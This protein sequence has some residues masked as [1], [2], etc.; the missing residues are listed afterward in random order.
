MR[1]P[2]T[3]PFLALIALVISSCSP[4]AVP[5]VQSP[6][7][8]GDI[9]IIPQPVRIVRV[10]G[11]FELN[12]E[13]KIVV[14]EEAGRGAAAIL[15]E[16]LTRHHG[17]GLAFSDG[18]DIQNSITFSQPSP[19]DDLGDEG[20]FLG[21]RPGR[22]QIVGSERGMF[23]AVNS[24]AQLLP[25]GFQT[26]ATIPAADIFDAPRFVYRGMHMDVARHF[27]KVEFVKKFI[28]LLSRYKFNYFHW[29]LTDDQG[30]RI[31][32]K[33][34]PRLTEIGSRRRE[35][36]VGR[37]E[38]PYV[39]DRI[40]VE[41]YYTQE[42][43]REV[44]AFAKSRYITVIPEI[45]MPG[46]SA[47]ALAAYPELGCRAGY[48]YQVQTTWAASTNILCPTQRT[49][50]FIADVVAEVVGLFPDSPYIHIGGDEVKQ[51]QWR[52]SGYVTALKRS[53]GLNS[54]PDM[55]AWF[56]RQAGR[57]VNAH[58]K[59]IIG[60]DEIVEGGAPP[61][62]VV[63]SWR[64]E[65][66][67]IAAARAGHKVIMTPSTFTYFDHPQGDPEFEP[68]GLGPQINLRK[69]YEY[70]PIPKTMSEAD[71]KFVM[72]AQGCVWTEFIKTPRDVEY[73]AFPRAL[74]LAEV[75]WSKKNRRN[76]DG[77]VD[78][79][80][81]EF[82]RLDRDNVNY[83]IPAPAGLGDRRFSISEKAVVDLKSAVPNG[84]IYYTVDGTDPDADSCLYQGP[85][86]LDLAPLQ[87]VK[88]RVRIIASETRKSPVFVAQYVRDT[89]A[90]VLK[91]P[92][93][94]E[95]SN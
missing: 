43:I 17:F 37:S 53:K 7:Q 36:M 76:Y 95:K 29:H 9:L 92:G 84:N 44:V 85:F 23:Y 74:A 75:L 81:N 15:N 33:K 83:R 12:R 79:L 27:M 87:M 22:I 68:P 69:V 66:G 45:E 28:D 19:A 55:N 61:D 13:T 70:E 52:E 58:E 2:L 94:P 89:V 30:W 14:N 46:H 65:E 59:S 91:I 50:E 72:G 47:A 86:V 5:P 3:K 90:R 1:I 24:L 48:K 56:I 39:G 35:S 60:W 77:F 78:R 26:A 64:G 8:V 80:A 18:A 20:Y 73:M 25:V 63:M 40:P 93:R 32:I 49:F 31:E 54:E 21:I 57:L 11:E 38:R 6:D 4:P 42:D 62:A 10:G 41:G 67:G 88:L 16:L 51:D 82:P 34:Y 71:A